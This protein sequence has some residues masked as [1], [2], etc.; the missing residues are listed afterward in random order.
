M[1]LCGLLAVGGLVGV[2]PVEDSASA[3]FIAPP[4]DFQGQAGSDARAVLRWY[5][6]ISPGGTVPAT[7]YLLFRNGIQ[8]ADVPR[9]T[10]EGTQNNWFSGPLPTGIYYFQ[11]QSVDAVG[12]TSVKTQ[13]LQIPVW[14][15]D[16]TKPS[17]VTGL[18][19]HAMFGNPVV[20]WD[21]AHDNIVVDHYQLYD[22]GA[23]I[24]P[25]EYYTDNINFGLG[26]GRHWLQVRTVDRAGNY[27]VLS[28]PLF[29]DYRPP[30]APRDFV[31]SVVGPRSIRLEWSPPSPPTGVDH[32]EISDDYGQTLAS[33]TATNVTISP[34][35]GSNFKLYV[36]AVDAFGYRS[37]QTPG[38]VI[39]LP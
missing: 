5:D 2:E 11:V 7:H 21:P 15:G 28:S 30:W 29:V 39:V 3:S 26:R 36:A 20:S 22:N 12:G 17:A 27:S 8:V 38:P 34:Q 18:R 31:G 35:F 4:V 37:A 6:W 14:V 10:G 9:H 19:V 32:Y 33:V 25:G 23:L 16:T 24:N 1:V 13:A